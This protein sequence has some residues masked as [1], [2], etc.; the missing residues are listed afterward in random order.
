[1]HDSQIKDLLTRVSFS[2]ETSINWGR[3]LFAGITV[4]VFTL[5]VFLKSFWRPI[6]RMLVQESSP[7]PSANPRASSDCGQSPCYHPLTQQRRPGQATCMIETVW[8]RHSDTA[9]RSVGGGES[10]PRKA[11]ASRL[12]WMILIQR[13]QTGQDIVLRC[14][15]GSPTQNVPARLANRDHQQHRKG[16]DRSAIT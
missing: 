7:L 3:G 11:V 5:G 16:L 10:L 1:M 13:L 15:R 12:S 9:R 8:L 6:L 14:T 4:V 2:I